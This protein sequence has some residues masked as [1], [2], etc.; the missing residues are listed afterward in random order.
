MV[1]GRPAPGVELVVWRV[2]G[3]PRGAAAR[4]ADPERRLRGLAAAM[5]AERWPGRAAGL[6]DEA[7]GGCANTASTADRSAPASHAELP[8]RDGQDDAASGAAGAYRSAGRAGGRDPVY[9]AASG[10]RGAA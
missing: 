8:R 3:G 1:H 6:L 9:D 7:A 4:A 10:A 2:C 5:D